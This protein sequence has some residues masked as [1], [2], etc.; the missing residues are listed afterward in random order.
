[1]LKN[2]PADNGGVRPGDILLMVDGKKVVDSASLLNLIADLN[3]GVNAQ[4]KVTRKQKQLN[5]KVQVGR[6]PMQRTPELQ[7]P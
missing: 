4:L 1:V 6:R 2:G 5:L 7:E 3:P